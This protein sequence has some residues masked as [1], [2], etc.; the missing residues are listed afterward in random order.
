MEGCAQHL[1]PSATQEVPAVFF[2][3]RSIFISGSSVW[4]CTLTPQFHEVCGCCPGSSATIGHP[5]TELYQRL[6]DISTI[7]ADGGSASR[8]HSRSNER[9]G[10]KTKCQEKCAFSTTENQLSGLGV[11]FN[12][13]A[14]TSVS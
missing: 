1:H 14:G 12:H 8:G 7:R 3:G 4:P 5:H 6:V 9:A 10:V 11:G 13:D 2:R